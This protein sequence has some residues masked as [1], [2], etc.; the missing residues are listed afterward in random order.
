[1]SLKSAKLPLPVNGRRR[2]SSLTSGGIPRKLKTGETA[3]VKR[4]VSPLVRRR[5][6]EI[7]IATRYGKIETISWAAP[8]AP[9]INMLY[10]FR[11]L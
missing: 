1:M 10:V 9:L 8:F 4:L 6:T 11:F 7:I 5:A 3:F 2:T